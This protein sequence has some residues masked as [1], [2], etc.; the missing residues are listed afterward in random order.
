MQKWTWH[1]TTVSLCF[2]SNL[3]S[4]SVTQPA[5]GLE[6]EKVEEVPITLIHESLV[7]VPQLLQDEIVREVPLP[8]YQEVVKAGGWGAAGKME[9]WG[10]V[11]VAFMI[12]YPYLPISCSFFGG[13]V[14]I[15]YPF[16]CLDAVGCFLILVILHVENQVG[17]VWRIFRERNGQAPRISRWTV[18]NE[19][20]LGIGCWHCEKWHTSFDVFVFSWCGVVKR[21]IVPWQKLFC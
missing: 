4:S 8:Q 17:D 2:T 5:S 10:V 1:G 15:I 9:A 19:L 7:E 3:A 6:V 16:S 13:V 18:F 11:A 20:R 14:F 21:I 12:I